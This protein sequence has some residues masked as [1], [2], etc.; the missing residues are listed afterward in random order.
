[1]E[2]PHF[3]ADTMLLPLFLAEV[4]CVVGY[5][6]FPRLHKSGLMHTGANGQSKHT[7][8]ASTS[9]ANMTTDAVSQAYKNTGMDSCIG[10]RLGSIK[11]KFKEGAQT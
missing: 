6:A 2:V 5:L 7:I 9:V 3:K 10:K 11:S 4:K 1:M 8:Q